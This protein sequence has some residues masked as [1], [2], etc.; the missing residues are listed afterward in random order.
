MTTTH[1]TPTAAE[2]GSS[3]SESFKASF[4]SRGVPTATS[5]QRVETVVSAVLKAV[6]DAISEN[7]VT[8]PEYQAA[9]AWLIEVGE[10]GEWPLFLD[11]FMEHV[12]EDVASRQQQGTKGTIEGPYY[13]PGQARLESKAALPHRDDEDGTP[14]VLSGQVRDVGGVPLAAAEIDIWQADAEGNYSG[15]APSVPAGNL[16][17]VV[18]ADS[19]GR[20]EIITVKPAPYQIP[21]D[22]PTGKL[23]NAAGWHPWRPAHF[24]VMIRA[25]GYRTI[26]SQLYFAGGEWLESDI[27]QAT[28]P[29]LILKSTPTEAGSEGATYDFELER[30]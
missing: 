11:V 28:K 3:A 16:R 14:F 1:N 25:E 30:A 18:V 10:T 4:A 22:G 13:L 27:A 17:G 26:T 20:F 7:D 21:H 6:H 23:I 2:A 8:Y 19:D 12:V 5:V 29:E 9:K 15:F 24:H